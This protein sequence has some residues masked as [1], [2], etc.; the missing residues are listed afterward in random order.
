MKRIFAADE[1]WG[2]PESHRAAFDLLA[3]RGV[4]SVELAGRLSG[5]TALRNRIAHGYVTV[6]RARIWQELPEGLRTL[7]DF[8]AATAAWLPDPEG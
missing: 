8:R 4:F 2:V 3:A 1:G 6:E 5:I 7:D